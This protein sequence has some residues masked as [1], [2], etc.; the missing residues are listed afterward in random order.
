MM[1]LLSKSSDDSE[2]FEDLM[3]RIKTDP[4]YTIADLV[5]ANKKSEVLCRPK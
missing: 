1:M 4:A 3:N 5:K 2:T